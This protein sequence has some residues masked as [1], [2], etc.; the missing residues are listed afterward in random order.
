MKSEF[1]ELLRENFI[2]KTID[3][4]IVYNQFGQ[5]GSAVWSLLV[6]VDI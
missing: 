4:Q 5:D 3:K 6:L 2:Y 1:E